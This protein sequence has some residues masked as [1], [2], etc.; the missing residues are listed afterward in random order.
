MIKLDPSAPTDEEH[1]EKKVTKL[2]YMQWRE[3]ESSTADFGFRI[4]GMKLGEEVLNNKNLQLQK[5]PKEIRQVLDQFLTNDLLRATFDKK[6]RELRGVL[7]KS[8]FFRKH[9]VRIFSCMHVFNAS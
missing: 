2:R 6:L 4:E 5:S 3:T 8:E 9:E 7:E 1:Q